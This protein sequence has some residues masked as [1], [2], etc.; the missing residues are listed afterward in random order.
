LT[1]HQS[2]DA[3]KLVQS[4]NGW[5]G[6]RH[7]DSAIDRKFRRPNFFRIAPRVLSVEG[8]HS[9]VLAWLLRPD[10]W[11]GLGDEFA[12]RLIQVALKRCGLSL[13]GPVVVN[14]IDLE[15]STGK[16]PIDILVRAKVGGANLVLGVENKIDS[17]EGDGQLARYGS[18]LKSLFP[19]D[20]V[21]LVLLAPQEREPQIAPSCVWTPLDYATIADLLEEAIAATGLGV[22]DPAG[23]AIA[24]HYLEIVRTNIMGESDPEIDRLC[25]AL[26][27][28]H[29][30]A[31]HVIRRR[32][33]TWRDEFHDQIGI[34]LTQRLEEEHGGNWA[35]SI[36]RN[37]YTCVFRPEWSALG[38]READTIVGLTSAT[39]TEARLHFRFVASRSD[40]DDGQTGGYEIRLKV[41]TSENPQL[42]AAVFEAICQVLEG[43]IEKQK[44]KAQF[45]IKV[46]S[47][48]KLSMP[49]GDS[50]SVP[51]PVLDWCEH[52]IKK[53][54]SAIDSVF[55]AR[56]NSGETG[57]P[58]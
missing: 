58:A 9:D 35:Y 36:R 30:E 51:D 41:T 6:L 22:G 17:P 50:L 47:S 39:H 37:R 26:Y 45:T 27:A 16:G 12:Q 15:F 25:Q 5:E 4:L 33:P 3:L 54:I 23:R 46:K 11:H 7:L 13:D 18:A 55:M 31:W 1:D 48:T 2:E 28:S 29:K 56:A 10:G 49:V 57:S 20:V 14:G 34:S 32:L 21:A 53:L 43:Q 42:G 44:G 40:T 8:V 38:S 19:N 52:H 24:A